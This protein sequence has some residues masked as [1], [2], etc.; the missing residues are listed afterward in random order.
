[1]ANPTSNFNWQMP[2]ASDLVTDL[3][4]DF[5]VFGQAVDTSLADLKGGT[6]NQVLAK[7]SNTDMDFK[8]VT[9]TA[10]M[11]NPMTTT[12]DTIYSSSGSTPARLGIG[13]TG[14]VLAVSG[15]VPAWTSSLT[16]LTTITTSSNCTINGALVG[17]GAG[18][19]DTNVALGV[20]AL[21]S[22]TGGNYNTAVGR[23][24]L[25]AITTGG[26]NTAVGSFTLN[27]TTGDSNTA[28]GQEAGLS[29]TTGSNNVMIGYAANAATATTSNTI[30]LGNSSIATLRCQQTSITALSDL[31]DKKNVEPLEIGLDFVNELK[32]VKYDWN[33]RQPQNPELDKDGKPK[34]IGKVDMPDVGFIAQDLLATE[35]ATGL[36]NYLQLTY[37]ENPEQLEATQ[38]RLIPILV[39]AIQE[40]SAKVEALEAAQA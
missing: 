15:G 17:I 38:G 18:N 25:T 14:Q 12:G 19:Q 8:W 26:R 13:S 21:D 4:A 20:G 28:I 6:T 2:T 29:L 22:N 23:D 16:S 32:P 30:T 33:M 3:P 1:M 7:N 10:G 9:D 5:E 40:L 35:D 31:R 24:T 39:K 34:I 27:T 36:A 37:R 11:T